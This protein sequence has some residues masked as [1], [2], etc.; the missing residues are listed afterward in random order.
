MR[1]TALLASA[2]VLGLLAPLPIQLRKAKAEDGTA[3]ADV[4][5]IE[6]IKPGMKGYGLTVFQG[7]QPERF[8]VEVIDVLKN[9]RPKQDLIL[10]KTK[11]PR[12]EVA[13]VVAGMSGSPIYLENKMV[14]AYAY[15]WT[16]GAEPV[17]GVTPIRNMI[18]DLV[19]PL[20]DKIYGWPLRTLPVARNSAREPG[21]VREPGS[22][23]G[24][25]DA[26]SRF[27]MEPL[28]RYSGELAKY[29]VRQHASSLAAR[30]SSSANTGNM[31]ALAPVATPLLV[32]GFTSGALAMSKELLAPL[33]LEPLAAGGSGVEDPNAPNRFVDGGA[34]GV[35]LVR[36]DMSAM[37]LGTV[38]RV[39]GDRLV[40]F[41]HPMMEAGVTA[42]PTAIG[43]VLWFLASDQRSFKIGMPV[44]SM[45]AMVNDRQASIVVS[46]NTR[47]PLI[48]VSVKIHGMP[49]L[50]SANWNFEIAHERFLSPSFV[51][52]SLGSALQAVA[53][54]HQ[55]VTWT[56]RS[57]VQL[58]GRAAIEVE[59]YGLSMGGTPDPGELG[60]SNLVRA[61]G[62][63]LNN[64]WEPTFVDGIQVDL[65]LSYARDVLR[66]RGAE[67]LEPE[68]EAG[69]PARI[70]LTFVPFSG[71]AQTRL[72]SVPLPA[73][74]A[75][76][77]VNMELLPGYMAD[78]EQAAPDSLDELIHN[79][80]HPTYPPKSLVVE[81]SAGSGAVAFRGRVAKHLPPS[82]LDALR[83]TSSTVAPDA[84]QTSN[85]EVVLLPKFVM[86][87]DRIS[88]SVR[89]VLR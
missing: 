83:P 23:L 81:F 39:E 73:H 43:K 16:F 32:G 37:G 82:A 4:L 71:P 66:L 24:A 11:H 3:R 5:P 79:L 56:A 19:R 30:G 34:I 74:L 48:P 17:A 61:V 78:R 1:F 9:F 60:R 84:F 57:K 49:G 63:I 65:E 86:G 27:G 46:Q 44:R 52:V 25:L 45:G 22:K 50:P 42:L 47:A 38:T 85:R 26:P 89:P 64:P 53:N 33:G 13:K 28:S 12:L 15:G 69:Q 18:E 68:V 40:A 87:R 77:T 58:R 21:A 72:V 67:L 14:G 10:I 51:A 80:E 6:R 70:K 35:Q 31:P 36:G 29:D 7:T 75:G 2:V 76:Q 59:D 88:V 62:S 41:G 20:P 54:E 55:D 8:D